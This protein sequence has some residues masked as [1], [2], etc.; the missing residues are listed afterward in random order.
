MYVVI[1]HARVY[2]DK[3]AIYEATFRELAAKVKA[4]ESGISFYELCRD[5]KAP[6]AYKV[7]EAYADQATQDAHLTTDYY[8]AASDVFMS[9]LVDGTFEMEV[10]E[11]I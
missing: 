2:P 5:P 4:R 7:V 1:V 9:C 6:C 3:V 11:T 8:K 10:C